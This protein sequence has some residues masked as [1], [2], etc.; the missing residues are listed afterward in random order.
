MCCV[1][2]SSSTKISHKLEV[3]VVLYKSMQIQSI[4]TVKCDLGQKIIIIII[5][6]LQRDV[7]IWEARWENIKSCFL[8]NDKSIKIN[9]VYT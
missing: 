5:K 7:F 9:L 1:I 3:H 2:T 8:K 6:I 4:N